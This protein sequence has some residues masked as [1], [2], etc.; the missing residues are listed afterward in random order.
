MKSKRQSDLALMAESGVLSAPAH[1]SAS[2]AEW[3][4]V[5]MQDWPL[6]EHHR[7]LLTLAAEA[8]DRCQ[9]ARAEIDEHGITYADRFGAPGLRPEVAVEGAPRLA[10]ARLVGELDLDAAPT[11]GPL[12]LRPRRK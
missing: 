6:E 8:W 4:L 12:A 7:R 5:V 9:Q 3:W 10:F 2:A 1:L 11:P